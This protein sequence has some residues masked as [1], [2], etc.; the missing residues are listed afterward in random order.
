[1][2]D[3]RIPIQ[4]GPRTIFESLIPIERI[5]AKRLRAIVPDAVIDVALPAIATG[6]GEKRGAPRPRRR[7]FVDVKTIHRGT[8]CYS[9]RTAEQGGA[10]RAREAQVWPEYLE[11][12]RKIDNACG[13]P[14]SKL[15][16][17]RP[18][19]FSETRGLV[20]GAYGEASA[21]VHDLIT[22][23][24][25]AQA[26]LQWKQAGARSQKEYRTYAIR[27]IR[28]RMGLAAV[29]EMARHTIARMPLINVPRQAV[30]D[31]MACRRR[32]WN[33][34]STTILRNWAPAPDHM[35]FYNYQQ[36]QTTMA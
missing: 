8:S 12:A 19:S 31:T 34:R 13:T 33:G 17:Q 7:L 15:I 10:V 26:R 4:L 24:A 1:M 2:E 23:A 9:K 28:R 20:F 18:R 14:G 6:V 3:A 36:A 21:D 29:Q 11:H 16:E 32:Q 27:K 5:T 35:E 25:E 22:A 30:E